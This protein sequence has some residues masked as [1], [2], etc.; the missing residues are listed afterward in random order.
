MQQVVKKKIARISIQ[1]KNNLMNIS[2]YICQE[3][4]NK[5]TQIQHNRTKQNKNENENKTLK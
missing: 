4:M 2:I 1:Q 3:V 5:I